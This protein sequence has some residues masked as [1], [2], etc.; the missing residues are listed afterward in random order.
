MSVALAA[1]CG[2]ACSV[3][4][5]AQA[6]DQQLTDLAAVHAACATADDQDLHDRLYS[7][8][9]DTPTT[10]VPREG[11]EEGE[12]LYTVPD[13][14]SLR[15]L[16]GSVQLVP[17]HLETIAF[18]ASGERAQIFEVAR[19]RG[20]RVRVGFFLGFDEPERRACLVRASQAV[21]AVR[22]DLA[23][24]EL[25]DAD[26]S[27]LAREDHDRLRA[28]SDD[29]DRSA[30]REPEVTVGSP[31]TI[32]GPAPEAW[33]RALRAGSVTRQLLACHV[34]GVG[35]GASREAMVQVRLRVDPRAGHIDDAVIEVGNVGDE[36]ENAC[37][38]R[39]VRAV[40]LPAVSGATT[41]IDVRLPVQLF[42]P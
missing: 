37:V 30:A 29:P 36:E 33:T 11:D 3:S 6:Q 14:R 39:A 8:V 28:W 25:L 26:G 18:V 35:R 17:S 42:S 21:T 13:A 10:L 24:V 38:L 5:V 7:V 20:A 12:V 16:G 27:V 32:N 15:A 2:L 22:I 23:F 41:P 31:T 19:A 1:A 34:Q 4:G 40:E 9:L